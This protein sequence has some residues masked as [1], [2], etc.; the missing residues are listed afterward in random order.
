[1]VMDN[2]SSANASKAEKLHGFG[3]QGIRLTDSTL[4]ENGAC[5]LV[6]CQPRHFAT[7]TPVGL[8]SQAPKP[9]LPRSPARES[10]SR[11]IPKAKHR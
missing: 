4:P 5:R 6:T 2:H 8:F 7:I 1:M 10:L 9:R 3:G 11:H